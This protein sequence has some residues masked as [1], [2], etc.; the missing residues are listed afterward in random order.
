MFSE[1]LKRCLIIIH[2]WKF[3]W[4]LRTTTAAATSAKTI[5]YEQ[6]K[7][8][9]K[10]AR[11][12]CGL[13]WNFSSKINFKDNFKN[14]FQYTKSKCFILYCFLALFLIIIKKLLLLKPIYIFSKTSVFDRKLKLLKIFT[15]YIYTTMVAMN[16]LSGDPLPLITRWQICFS[17][18]WWGGSHNW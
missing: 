14:F 15:N 8:N 5:F 16:L 6:L 3:G 13:L 10:N 18:E 9:F 4:C 12:Y 11:S 1:N 2:E 17:M 7:Y